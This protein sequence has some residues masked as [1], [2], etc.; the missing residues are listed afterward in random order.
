LEEVE[1]EGKRIS[2][3]SQIGFGQ[4]LIRPS[5]EHRNLATSQFVSR[6]A[7]FIRFLKHSYLPDGTSAWFTPLGN[8]VI[9]YIDGVRIEGLD[10][11]SN[12]YF[13]LNSVPTDEIDYVIVS[14]PIV[15]PYHVAIIT[16]DNVRQPAKGLHKQ[17][18]SGYH[19]SRE[20]YSPKYGPRDL[21]MTERDYRITL[22]WNPHLVT[23]VNGNAI[24][25]FYNTDVTKQLHVVVEGLSRGLTGT[26]SQV[27]GTVEK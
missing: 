25:K 6:Y 8:L 11:M 26:V 4:A 3:V 16:R 13:I 7:P 5:E 19:K 10:P 21:F 22:Y 12:P 17:F 18:A 15:G 14:E 24:V 1:I 2:N 20:F 9:F 27:F 23:D